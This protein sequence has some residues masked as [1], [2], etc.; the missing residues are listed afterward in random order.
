MESAPPSP[1]ADKGIQEPG[2]TDDQALNTAVEACTVKPGSP[3]RRSAASVRLTCETR[4]R[5][6]TGKVS[7]M[8]RTGRHSDTERSRRQQRGETSPDASRS[9]SRQN[10][11]RRTSQRNA[12]S[13]LLAH[14]SRTDGFRRQQRHPPGADRSQPFSAVSPSSAGRTA[15]PILCAATG[16]A[17]GRMSATYPLPGDIQ[18][19]SCSAGDSSPPCR[20]RVLSST[21]RLWLKWSAARPFPPPRPAISRQRPRPPL[22]TGNSQRGPRRFVSLRS[23]RPAPWISSERATELGD[24]RYPSPRPSPYTAAASAAFV[25]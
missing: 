22:Q 19:V 11:R 12:L 21:S 14:V 13:L 25:T 23:L 2:Y 1:P 10:R 15:E 7:R 3:G 24:L 8:I 20:T 5:I 16:Q 18:V 17:S 9:Q 4:V 6:L